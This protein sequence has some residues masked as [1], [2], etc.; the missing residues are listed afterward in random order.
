MPIKIKN[1]EEAAFLF[2]TLCGGGV[3]L[4]DIMFDITK[5]LNKYSTTIVGILFGV[6]VIWWIGIFIF[7]NLWIKSATKK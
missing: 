5:E 1:N 4:L 7:L 2:F 6:V 3:F